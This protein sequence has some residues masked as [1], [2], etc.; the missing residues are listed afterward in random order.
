[1][2][3]PTGPPAKDVGVGSDPCPPYE[4]G[5]IAYERDGLLVDAPWPW[6]AGGSE[7]RDS[8]SREIST[9]LVDGLGCYSPARTKV[10]LW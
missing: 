3:G 8:R 9:T 10:S 6:W 2:G 5:A 4:A 7:S 1:V